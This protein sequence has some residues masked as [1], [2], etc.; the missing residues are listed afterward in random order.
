MPP[1]NLYLYRLL[2]P[3]LKSVTD[4]KGV[5]LFGTCKLSS[6]GRGLVKEPYHS[7][8]LA[9]IRGGVVYLTRQDYQYH[10]F[11][12]SDPQVILIT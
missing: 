8:D 1:Y 2:H 9:V 10:R 12:F 6:D 4:G 7:E 5:R 11:N 3:L